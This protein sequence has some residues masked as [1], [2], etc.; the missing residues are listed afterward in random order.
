MLWARN[1]F[2]EYIC[3]HLRGFAIVEL[4]R[5]VLYI[6]SNKVV[7]HVEISCSLLRHAVVGD[8]DASLVVLVHWHWGFDSNTHRLEDLQQPQ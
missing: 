5:P 2:S 3:E 7:S 6:V 1:G 4:D 8:G